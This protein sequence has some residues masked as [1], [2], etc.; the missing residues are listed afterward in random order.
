MRRALIHG[1]HERAAKAAM[2]LD[3]FIAGR[4][5]EWAAANHRDGG[6][7]RPARLQRDFAPS[8]AEA[9]QAISRWD[10]DGWRLAAQRRRGRSPRRINRTANVL[11]RALAQAVEWGLIPARPFAGLREAEGRLRRHGPLP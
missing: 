8:H 11:Q 6:G 4:Y 10:I 3:E 9:T 1:R 7:D 5:A 2:T